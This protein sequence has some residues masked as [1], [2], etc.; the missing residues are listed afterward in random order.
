MLRIREIKRIIG[1]RKERNSPQGLNSTVGGELTV[2]AI[3][4]GLNSG[5]TQDHPENHQA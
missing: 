4:C 1:N 3:D 2:H 5:I